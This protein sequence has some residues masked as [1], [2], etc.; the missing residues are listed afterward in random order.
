MEG[1]HT[2]L[3]DS[4]ADYY[5]SKLA[6]YGNTPKGVDWNS[7]ESQFLRFA[8]LSK[9]ISKE[10][11]FSISDLGCG[12]GVFLDYLQAYYKQFTYTGIDVSSDMVKAA[13]AQYNS[14][15]NVEFQVSDR[16]NKITDYCVASGIFNVRLNYSE[17]QWYDYIQTTLDILNESCSIGFS[18]NCLTSYSDNDKKRPDLYYADPCKLFDWCKKRYTRH[19]SLLHDYGLYEFTLLVRKHI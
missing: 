10:D 9:I 19:V 11:S 7:Q 4:V 2:K 8:Q 3:L 5:S 6:Q 18:F 1:N 12:Y 16:P 13:V 14:K 15:D 17:A